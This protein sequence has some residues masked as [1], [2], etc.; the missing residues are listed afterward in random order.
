M[1]VSLSVI[2]WYPL[3]ITVC[4]FLFGSD[5]VQDTLP[6]KYGT[7]GI[8]NTLSWKSMGKWQS[9][10]VT[11]TS[12]LP[13]F[14]ETGHKTLMWVVTSLYPEERSVLISEDQ[15]TP[16]R[17][18]TADF[19]QSPSVH[20]TILILLFFPVQHTDFIRMLWEH[21]TIFKLGLTMEVTLTCVYR[22][23]Q[24]HLPLSAIPEVQS[25]VVLSPCVNLA[26]T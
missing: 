15:G 9:K 6:N 7:L 10:K 19:V 17:I 4:S 3:N 8:L 22:V 24:H 20:Y 12:F 26:Q 13:L 18:L 11:L 5:G 16:W 1:C 23:C 21:R 25:V 2:T 14:P